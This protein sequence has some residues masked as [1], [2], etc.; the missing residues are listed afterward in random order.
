[1]CAA[2]LDPFSS[3]KNN[4]SCL[5]ARSR[6]LCVRH[7]RHPLPPGGQMFYPP[8]FLRTIKFDSISLSLSLFLRHLEF[9][10]TRREK[11]TRF[12]DARKWLEWVR[13]SIDYNQPGAHRHADFVHAISFFF[14]LFLFLLS[15]CFLT[16]NHRYQTSSRERE[17]EKWW[18][19]QLKIDRRIL[20][21]AGWWRVLR[22]TGN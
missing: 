9:P 3:V 19:R 22:C 14:F 6:P 1:M 16:L 11:R 10:R 2:S 21:V 17:R 8:Y 15:C 4:P 13:N 7:R 18:E 12:I 20:N 5:C